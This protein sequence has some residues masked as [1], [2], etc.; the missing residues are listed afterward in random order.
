LFFDNILPFLINTILDFLVLIAI[1]VVAVTVG[2][3]LSYLNCQDVGSVDGPSS[4][5]NFTNS[6]EEDSLNQNG[7]VN[8]NLWVSATEPIC[9]ETKAVW[10]LSIALW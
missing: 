7:T 6:L 10:G 2:K 9:L 1:I 8:F 5:Y 4:A 3:P